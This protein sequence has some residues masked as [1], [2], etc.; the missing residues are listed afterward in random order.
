MAKDKIHRAVRKALEKDDWTITA[1]PFSFRY[2][3]I[4][5]H[6]DLEAERIFEAES[7]GRKIAVEIKSFL[8][9]SAIDD[10]ED[11]LGQYEFY[12]YML[13]LRKMPH[14]L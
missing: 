7:E 8:G 1:D 5:V 3:R 14:R 10:F 2:K 9:A 13:L 6:A 11:A 4:Q 12:R